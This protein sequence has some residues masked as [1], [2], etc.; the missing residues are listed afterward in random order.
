MWRDCILGDGRRP[1]PRAHPPPLWAVAAPASHRALVCA[2]GVDV[3]WAVG[4]E[5]ACALVTDRPL[6]LGVT[7]PLLSK[8]FLPGGFS[9]CA[10]HVGMGA[11]CGPWPQ[12]HMGTAGTEWAG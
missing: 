4:C 5:L 8:L 12:E 7:Q 9:V 10:I 6:Q 3:R 11:T 2:C 1:L